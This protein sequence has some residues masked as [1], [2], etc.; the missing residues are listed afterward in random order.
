MTEPCNCEQALAAEARADAAERERDDLLS[1]VRFALGEWDSLRRAYNS[2][3]RR[4]V[5]DI[6]DHIP[7]RCAVV[8]RGEL[9]LG[10]DE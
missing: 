8:V 3:A 9:L 7:E 4:P 10:D 5:P 1:Y 2:V 6:G